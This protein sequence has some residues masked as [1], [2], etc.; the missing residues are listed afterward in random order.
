M[1]IKRSLMGPCRAP[2]TARG[3]GNGASRVLPRQSREGTEPSDGLEPSTP[4]LPRSD[5]SHRVDRV[6]GGREG[7]EREEEAGPGESADEL[8]KRPFDDGRV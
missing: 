6:V 2:A 1:A 4:A 7:G 8:P 5:E 3:A